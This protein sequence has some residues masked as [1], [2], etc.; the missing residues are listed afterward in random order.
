MDFFE[1]LGKDLKCRLVESLSYGE[2]VGLDKIYWVLIW[3]I[4]IE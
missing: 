3:I 1:D 4:R 2:L